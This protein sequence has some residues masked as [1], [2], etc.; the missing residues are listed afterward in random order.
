LSANINVVSWVAQN[1]LPLQWL[2]QGRR[3][4]VGLLATTLRATT[5]QQRWQERFRLSM[6]SVQPALSLL[7]LF[8]HCAHVYTYFIR[9]N[10]AIR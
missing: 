6:L 9:T 10:E 5:G 1:C 4:L 3:Q 7:T 8:L 2:Q